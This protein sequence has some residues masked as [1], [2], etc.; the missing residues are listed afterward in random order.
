MSDYPKY[1]KKGNYI[2]LDYIVDQRGKGRVYVIGPVGV[3]P[4][5][6]KADSLEV[7]PKVPKAVLK[8]LGPKRD[9]I[10]QQNDEKIKRLK[11]ENEENE[12]IAADKNEEPAVLERASDKVIKNNEEISQT[13][14]E[15]EQL[16]EGKSLSERL[17]LIFKKYGWTL[18]AVVLAAGLVIGAVTLAAMNA[19][20]TATKAVGNG[21]KV[22][23]KSWAPSCPAS[24]ARSSASSSKRLDKSF[25]FSVS[26]L[27]Y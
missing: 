17:K 16:R 23:G 13:E 24:S 27:G 18:Q 12:R 20:K 8:V 14:N 19:L 5:L 1:G 22:V 9:E 11:K 26:T 10:I 15:N 3:K 21:L 2:N 4:F 25:P 7:N 6:F